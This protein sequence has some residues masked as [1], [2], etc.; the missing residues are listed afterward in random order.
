M[1]PIARPINGAYSQAFQGPSDTMAHWAPPRGMHFYPEMGV[2]REGGGVMGGGREG[3]GR[4]G[5]GVMFARGC[6]SP[7]HFQRF[8]S[9]S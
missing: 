1:G 2:M 3:G 8:K 5:G 9:L 6:L 7:R 4:W